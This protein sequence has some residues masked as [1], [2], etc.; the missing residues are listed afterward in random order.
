VR[1][2]VGVVNDI[3]VP[4]LDNGDLRQGW[5]YRDDQNLDVIGPIVD[6]RGRGA[7]N[8]DQKATWRRVQRFWPQH[9][10][11]VRVG[12]R[13]LLPKVPGWGRW[14][15]VEVTGEYR[16]ERHPDSGDHGHILPVKTL[17]S[18]ISSTNAAVGA[19]LQRTMRNQGP[20]WNI[21]GLAGE[22]DRLLQASGDVAVAD[23]ATV[24]LKGVLDDTLA[25]LINRLRR[26]F[27]SNQLEE[28][29]Y[30]LL[31]QLFEGATVDRTAGSGEHGAD[32]VVREADRFDHERTT[33]IQLKDYEG[34]L[35]GARPLEQ[36]R[37]A[38]HWYGPAAAVIITTAGREA[39]DFGVARDKLS[40][41]L[42]IPVTVVH[43][44]QLARWFLS[45]LEAVAAD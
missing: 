17:I 36:I 18:E 5:A 21:D 1:T 38:Y 35:S 22:V 24:R 29:V 34:V 15:L 40:E 12:H 41:E 26:D 42:G 11:P 23:D 39:S 43:G 30:R 8:D 28:P 45:H 7:L 31:R 25:G 14:R 13:I 37:E 27:R 6:E 10:E 44:Q 9:W 32:F 19:G 3:I 4:S 20:M 33:V 2:D 16:F